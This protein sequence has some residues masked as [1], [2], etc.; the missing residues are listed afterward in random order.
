MR[1]VCVANS[2]RVNQVRSNK[3]MTRLIASIATCFFMIDV[4]CNVARADIITYNV[5]LHFDP[6]TID[7]SL[8]ANRVGTI[9]GTITID[10]SI[11]PT[12]GTDPGNVVAINLTEK[13]NDGIFLSGFNTNLVSQTFTDIEPYSFIFFGQPDSQD[14]VD[15]QIVGNPSVPYE[16]IQVFSPP[17]FDGILVGPSFQFDFP[18][19]FG[20][21]VL[22]GNFDSITGT[23]SYLYGT[24]EPLSSVPEPSSF[25]LLGLGGLLSAIGVNRRR[26]GDVTAA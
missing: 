6:T 7:A 16:F 4:A 15:S 25:A 9:T 24:V 26:R 23:Y 13:S 5:D 21:Q 14:Q 10:T 18:F 17:L 1:S 3:A 11:Q 22:P 20:G 19:P 8:Q 2:N 12:K